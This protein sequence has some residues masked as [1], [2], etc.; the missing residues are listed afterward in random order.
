VTLAELLKRPHFYAVAALEGLRGEATVVDGQLTVTTVDA[1]GRLKPVTDSAGELQAT[2]LVGD[3]VDSWSE[4]IVPKDV[5]ADAFDQYV[6]EVAE[7]AGIDLRQPFV[8]ILEGSLR[9]VR[10]HVINGA[11]PL[12]AR[13]KKIDLAA[14]KHPFEAE[15][16]EIKGTI[17]GV[18]AK[19][20]VGKLTHPATSTHTHLVFTDPASQ[21]KATGHV[22]QV[23]I[24]KG[25]V[26]RLPKAKP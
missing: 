3:Y 4:H 1:H 19:D 26:L 17:V 8:F 13:M 23:G 6:A 10:L 9:D 15:F 7:K 14:D 22:E 11:C 25:S 18:F 5:P 16:N 21:A 12:H 2:L 20:A 24:G